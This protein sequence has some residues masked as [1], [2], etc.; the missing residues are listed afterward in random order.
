MSPATI[1]S[2]RAHWSV[3]EEAGSNLTLE[4]S[5]S[6]PADI[7]VPNWSVGT[8]SAFD[9]SLTSPLNLNVLSEVGVTAGAAT[10]ATELWKHEAND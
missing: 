6:H 7:L 3:K 1:H 9:L 8:P 4:H 5:H 10:R 2:E